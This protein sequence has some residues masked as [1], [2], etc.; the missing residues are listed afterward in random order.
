MGGAFA[1]LFLV[2][3]G[4]MYLRGVRGADALRRSYPRCGDPWCAVAM[5]GARRRSLRIRTASPA[6]GLL[7]APVSAAGEVSRP[8][9]TPISTESAKRSP[10]GAPGVTRSPEPIGPPP[11]S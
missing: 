8:N 10:A 7:S 9:P 5:F 3:L 11:P 4:V 6:A 1:T 2:T